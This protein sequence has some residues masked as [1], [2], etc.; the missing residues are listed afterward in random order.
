MVYT[1]SP[2]NSRRIP[3]ERPRVPLCY[4]RSQDDA[5]PAQEHDASTTLVALTAVS[6]VALWFAAYSGLVF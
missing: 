4:A 5:K 6:A 3:P 2:R 1:E